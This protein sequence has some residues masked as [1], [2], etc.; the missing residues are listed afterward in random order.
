MRRVS[1]ALGPD[2]LAPAHSL[3]A[4]ARRET[5]AAATWGYAGGGMLPAARS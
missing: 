1:V 2:D 3:A 5:D 4:D